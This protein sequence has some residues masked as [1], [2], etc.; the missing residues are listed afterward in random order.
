MVRLRRWLGSSAHVGVLQVF[1]VELVSK[2]P[3]KNMRLLF[4]AGASSPSSSAAVLA[5]A[6][7]RGEP[8]IISVAALEQ[9][10][11]SDS[12]LKLTGA[13]DSAPLLERN[14]HTA[15]SDGLTPDR[16]TNNSMAAAL[17]GQA[18]PLSEVLAEAARAYEPDWSVT[19]ARRAPEPG[20]P[21][22]EWQR[23]VLAA[24]ADGDAPALVLL[25][26]SAQE[27]EHIAIRSSAAGATLAGGSRPLPGPRG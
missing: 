20:P 16:T 2:P 27:S 21:L 7:A 12:P 3:K 9:L 1:K 8:A 11:G 13:S 15:C 19:V 17:V 18:E 14:T 24:A 6:A 5:E 10:M 4:P 25:L 26:Q 22:T 23:G